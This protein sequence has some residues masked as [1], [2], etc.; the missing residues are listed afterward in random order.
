MM[1]SAQEQPRTKAQILRDRVVIR[2]A[3]PSAGE[4]IAELLEENGIEMPPMNWS[5]VSGNWL[6]ATV[7]E[8]VIGCVMVLPARPFGF[9]EFLIVNPSI[10]FKL[11]AIAVRK[12]CIQAAATL[13]AF[14]CDAMFCYVDEST[15][16]FSDILSKHGMVKITSGSLHM[17]RL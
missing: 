7:D 15:R 4:Y 14:G 17:K 12:L 11:R 3:I 2:I 16:K 6:L 10:S 13:A 5:T 8:E 9:I 1:E